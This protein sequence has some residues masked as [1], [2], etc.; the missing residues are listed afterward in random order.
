[1]PKSYNTLRALGALFAGFVAVFA[2]SLGTDLVLHA[3]NVYPAWGKSMSNG[4]FALAT[5][6]RIVYTL[7][8]GYITAKLAPDRPMRYAM[9]LGT[10]GTFFALMGV[11]A[12][13]NK[14][15]LGPKW[16]PIVLVITALPCCLAGGKL[17]GEAP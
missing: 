5:A 12:T 6:Y 17:R 4:L 14:P 2:L 9:I 15:E 8:G 13:W 3:M 10:I 7:L 11:V 1:M 16:Y